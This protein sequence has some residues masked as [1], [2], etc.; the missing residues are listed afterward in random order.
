MKGSGELENEAVLITASHMAASARTAPK[1]CGIDNIEVFAIDDEKTRELLV[2]KMI[3]ISKNEN[4]DISPFRYLYKS[5][6]IYTRLTLPGATVKSIKSAA[7][8][9]QQ[10]STDFPL[11]QHRLPPWTRNLP[12]PGHPSRGASSRPRGISPSS[13]PP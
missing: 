3:E 11:Q 12:W 6:N 8:A 9:E 13:P 4:I 1:T 10:A 5:I 2:S 7:S